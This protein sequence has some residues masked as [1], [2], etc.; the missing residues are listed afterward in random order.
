[1]R[2]TFTTT[3]TEIPPRKEEN[4]HSN[5]GYQPVEVETEAP[6][7]V[8]AGPFVTMP[9]GDEES[10]TEL[11]RQPKRAEMGDSSNRHEIRQGSI[12]C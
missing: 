9:Q 11:A 12:F 6:K 10:L 2:K 5:F 7:E 1:M 3:T 4:Y 8:F